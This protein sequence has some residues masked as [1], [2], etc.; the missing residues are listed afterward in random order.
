M[1]DNNPPPSETTLSQNLAAS[2]SRE[3][4]AL[5]K[6]PE[7]SKQAND[8]GQLDHTEPTPVNSPPSK[9]RILSIPYAGPFFSLGFLFLLAILLMQLKTII[10]PMVMAFFVCCILNPLV[11]LFS[12]RL[13]L[14][15]P[16][17]I[18]LSLAV[19]FGFIWLVFNYIVIS[20]TAFADGFP[21]YSANFT[22]LV[23]YFTDKINKQ[24]DFVSLSLIKDQL[25]NISFAGLLSGLLNYVMSFTGKLLL[26]VLF[27]L[28][29]LPALSGLP[30][31]LRRSFPE[32]RGQRL[33][34]SMTHFIAQVQRFMLFKT[35]FSLALGA[36]VTLICYIFRVDFAGTW[37]IFAFFLNFIPTLGVPIAVLPP[38]M[39]CLFQFNLSRAIWLLVIL[40]SVQLVHGSYVE[41]KF[42]GRSVNL[43]PTATLLSV[44]LWGWLWGLVGTIIA[45]PVMAAVKFTCDEIESLKPVGALM[46]K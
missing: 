39:V 17:A 32:K 43:S 14:P 44:M 40:L 45:L 6:V 36:V 24:F 22:D 41:N 19:G 25:S 33:S 38:A 20:L 2:P 31:K 11:F 10:L 18:I 35:I 7:V 4:N 28:Y 26:T 16:I 5:R 13:R 46:G 21:K 3:Q 9:T 27:T 30:D 34:R 8:L 37:G 42:L 15:R 23:N 29:F 1:P 12:R